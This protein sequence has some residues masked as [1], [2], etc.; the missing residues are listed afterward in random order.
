MLAISIDEGDAV[1]KR[2]WSEKGLTF[3][4]ASGMGSMV[5]IARRQK[6]VFVGGEEAQ[7][8]VLRQQGFEAITLHRRQK[9]IRLIGQKQLHLAD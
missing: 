2:F 1:I 6:I 9:A 7:K 4:A 5:E 3:P 8:I